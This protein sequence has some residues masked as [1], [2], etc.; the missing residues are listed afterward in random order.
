MKN[1]F[2]TKYNVKTFPTFLVLDENGQELARFTG[3]LKKDKFLS[4]VKLALNPKQQLPYLK[5]EYEKDKT[6]GLNLMRYLVALKK[7][8]DGKS[9]NSDGKEVINLDEE[10]KDKKNKDN[11]KLSDDDQLDPAF[12]NVGE[13]KIL[14][15]KMKKIKRFLEIE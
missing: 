11:G 6:N 14:K 15:E 4:E 5:A 2:K 12:L 10:Q 8:K 3:E 7:G 1:N 13:V 9:I